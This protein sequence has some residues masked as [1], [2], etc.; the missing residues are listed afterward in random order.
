MA[1]KQS[2]LII[3]N[4]VIS[5][6][7]E[8]LESISI[9]FSAHC[10]SCRNK[11]TNNNNGNITNVKTGFARIEYSAKCQYGSKNDFASAFKVL[12][13]NIYDQS[14]NANNLLI[15]IQNAFLLLSKIR[16]TT[17]NQY[18]DVWTNASWE[19]YTLAPNMPKYGLGYFQNTISGIY[20]NESLSAVNEEIKINNIIEANDVILYFNELCENYYN[21]RNSRANETITTWFCYSRCHLACHSRSRR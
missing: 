3:R 19:S 7:S 1:I 14:I 16:N 9:T 6:F 8:I 5:K 21:W 4:E 18:N 2:D 17:H 11:F 20:L 13:Q 15:S 12:L 10:Q